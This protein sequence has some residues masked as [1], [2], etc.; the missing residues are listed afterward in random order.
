[1][2]EYSIP[3]AKE[4]STIDYRDKKTSDVKKSHSTLDRVM[5]PESNKLAKQ[6]TEESP[7]NLPS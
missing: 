6:N 3:N 2:N 4:E 7:A 5:N 1:M